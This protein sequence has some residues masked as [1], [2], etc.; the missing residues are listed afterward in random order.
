MVLP[1]YEMEDLQRQRTLKPYAAQRIK[2]RS[3][4]SARLT[5]A[6]YAVHRFG[7]HSVA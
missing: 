3:P 4:V 7:G 1:T 5:G 6:K 2:K